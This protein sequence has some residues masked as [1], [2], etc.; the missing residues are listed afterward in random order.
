V[1]LPVISGR[2]VVKALTRAGFRVAGRR[3]SHIKLKRKVDDKVFVVI[4]P[5]HA[6]LARGTLKSIL[7]QANITRE[8]FLKL[9]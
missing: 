9:L 2:K 8:A 3:G 7:R 4:V 1:A 6:E 5:D